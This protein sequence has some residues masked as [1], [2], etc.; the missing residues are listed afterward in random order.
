MKFLIDE[1]LSPKIRDRIEDLFPGSVHVFDVL[2]LSAPDIAI[3]QFAAA[4]EFA[5]LSKDND[6]RQRSLASGHPPKTVWLSLSNANTAKVVSILRR[7]YAEIGSFEISQSE[8]LLIIQ[9]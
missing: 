7:R 9:G 2:P 3:W 4:N 5:I 8:S 1:N 6:F